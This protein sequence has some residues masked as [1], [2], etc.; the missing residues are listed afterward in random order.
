MADRGRPRTLGAGR[1]AGLA[2]G[3]LVLTVYG[4]IIPLRYH[5]IP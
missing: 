2:V 4:S 5:P 1:Y 3:L